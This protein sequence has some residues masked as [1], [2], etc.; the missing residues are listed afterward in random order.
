MLG[1]LTRFPSRIL[2]C[3][4][5][6]AM[7]FETLIDQRTDKIFFYLNKGVCLFLCICFRN[8]GRTLNHQKNDFVLV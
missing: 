3:G 1:Y 4:A 7:F 2:I 6:G 8:C 5:A